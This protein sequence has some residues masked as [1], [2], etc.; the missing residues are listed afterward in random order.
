MS[1]III[2]PGPQGLGRETWPHSPGAE[3]LLT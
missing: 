2:I 1:A 3:A